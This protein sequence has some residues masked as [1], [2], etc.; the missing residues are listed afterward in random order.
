M[1]R[2]TTRRRMIQATAS[3]GAVLVAG[4]TDLGSDGGNG[5]STEEDDGSTE[6]DGSME[7]DGSMEDDESMEEDSMSGPQAVTVRIENVAPTDFYGS[8]TSTGGGIWITPGAYAVH[9]G[10]NPVYAEGESASVGLEAVAEAGRPGGF[11][12]E[13]SL[14]D[15]LDA[16]SDDGIAHSGAWTPEDTVDDPNDPTGEV[17]GAPPIAPGGAFEFDVEVDPGQRL[18]F[19]TMFVPSNDVFF[20]PGSE[21]IILWPEDGEI[22]DGDVTDDVELWDAGTEPNAE[23]PGEGPDQ[24]P[25]D[26]PPQGDAEGGVV[27]PLDDVDDSYDYPDV[28][29]AIQV[30]VTPTEMMDDGSM[31][32]DSSMEET[33]SS[34]EEDDS[35]E[36]TDSSMEDDGS[37][38]EDDEG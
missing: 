15:E 14:V 38:E 18:S 4:C 29:E 35:M 26:D 30:T 20:S 32:D 1:P 9:T 11:E 19:A 37:M 12:G 10:G 3:A 13:D 34:M 16:M 31:E 24:A 36:E 27:R 23:P 25:Q 33:D 21:G 5:G 17:P 6:D 28:S 2:N 22:V 8:E 7:E